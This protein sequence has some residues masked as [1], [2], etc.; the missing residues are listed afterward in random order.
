[1]EYVRALAHLD[2]QCLLYHTNPNATIKPAQLEIQPHETTAPTCKRFQF[3]LLERTWVAY[4]SRNIN[5][6]HILKAYN[7]PRHRLKP[8]RFRPFLRNKVL[9]GGGVGK[10][11]FVS[12]KDADSICKLLSIDREFVRSIIEQIESL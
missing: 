5:I 1:M 12:F 8:R 3:V 11:T 9:V 7:I 6:T 10:G 2:A 4:D